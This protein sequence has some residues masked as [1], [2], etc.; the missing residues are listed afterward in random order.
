MTS[1]GPQTAVFD[2]QRRPITAGGFVKTGPVIF[3]DATETAGLSHW[4]NVTGGADKRVIIEA[5]GSGV[6]LLDYDDDGW[7]DIYLVNGSTLDAMAGKTPSPHAALFH[8]NHDGT[9]TDVTEKAG[10][11]GEGYGMGVAVGDFDNDGWPDLYVANVT[12]N[13]LFRN[14]H[15]GTFTDVTNRAHV[16]G[17]VVDGKKMWSV[18][19]VWLDYNNDGLLDLFVSNYCK[20]EVNQDP[21]CRPTPT[22]RSY[23]HPKY[24]QP[25]PNTLYRNNG[26]GTFTDVSAETGIGK[27]F[28]KGMGVV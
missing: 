2:T 9:F 26:D 11:A 8:N 28:G 14:N 13:Q 12:G 27:H 21:V 18:S 10:V 16:G 24:Y 5:K 1:A 15:D 3:M 25:L 7:L 4:R 6:C 17:G 20:W 22:T 19:A 23:C